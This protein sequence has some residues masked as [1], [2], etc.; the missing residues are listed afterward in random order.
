MKT[1]GLG[2]IGHRTRDINLRHTFAIGPLCDT[3]LFKRRAR[4]Y[5]CARCSWSFLVSGSAAAVIDAEGR[6]LAGEEAAKRF[7]SFENG[8]CPVL[9]GL[10]K[11]LNG[12]APADSL[13]D[14]HSRRDISDH[15]DAPESN[16]SQIT[17]FRSWLRNQGWHRRDVRWQA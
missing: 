6:P 9:E 16:V 12:R 15:P 2:N 4:L 1:R 10:A 11:E 14:G 7:Q 5:Y 8:P 17:A 13:I 3:Y